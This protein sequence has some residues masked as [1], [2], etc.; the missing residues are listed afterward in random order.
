MGDRIADRF[1]ILIQPAA[2]T[3][4]CRWSVLD[5]TIR[6]ATIFRC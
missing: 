1:A 3:A 5:H 4:A 2:A 6:V